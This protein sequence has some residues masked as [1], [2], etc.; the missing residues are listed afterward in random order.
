MISAKQARAALLSLA[1]SE[2]QRLAIEAIELSDE[3]DQLA[4]QDKA[5]E[6][7]SCK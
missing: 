7:L 3:M 2:K 4:F 6:A 5:K 1:S